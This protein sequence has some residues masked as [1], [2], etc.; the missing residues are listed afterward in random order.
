MPASDTPESGQLPGRYEWVEEPAPGE[1]PTDPD[2]QRFSDV[3]RSFEA[4]AGASLGRQD[5]VSTPDAV[6][7]N[8]AMEEPS[9]TTG[10]DLQ[11]FPVD[12]AGDPVDASAYGILRNQYNQLP[13]TLLIGGRR[14]H[15]GGNDG[16]GVREYTVARGAR[17]ESVEPTLDP[18]EEN[19]ILLEMQAQPQKVRSYLIHQPSAATTVTVESENQNDIALDVTIEDEDAGTAETISLTEETDANGNFV[20]A[21]ATT[22]SE[23]ADIDAIWI[24]DNPVGDVTVTDGSGTTLCGI[25]GGLTYS[26]DDQPV[27]GDRGV[28]PLGAGS[29]AAEIGTSFEHFVGDRFERAGSAL[30][31][32][33]NSASWTVENDLETNALSETRAP[34]VDEGNRTVSVDA[35]VAGPFVS[36]QSMMESLQKDQG[37]LE[38]ELSGGIIRFK[39]TVPTDS[40]TRTVEADQGVASLSETLEASGDPAIEL[41]AN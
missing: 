11:Q 34:S 36:H 26:D 19:P 38:H 32:R 41:E 5:G 9:L 3:V 20:A 14:E 4:E 37:D 27:D 24:S 30:R 29:H 35:D 23:F 22:Q 2:W 6:D 18:S 1:V 7:H 31:A 28:P 12:A 25:E 21:N 15:P 17:V 39:N 10:Y 33:V 16:A 8:R 13:G 40:A